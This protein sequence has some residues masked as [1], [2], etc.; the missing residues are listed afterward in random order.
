ML[1]VAFTVP[2]RCVGCWLIALLTACLLITPSK[3]PS[4]IAGSAGLT[5]SELQKSL[6]ES[7]AVFHQ[8]NEL[9]PHDRK[10]AEE[11]YR[12]AAL[13]LERI[14]EQG[15]VRNGRLYYNLGNI[16]LRLEQLGHAILCYRKAEK[17]I[18][19]DEN[20]QQNLAYTLQLRRDDIQG[21]ERNWILG[22]LFGQ[23]GLSPVVRLW[24]FLCCFNLFWI[25]NSVALFKRDSA[26]KKATVLS[27]LL[28]V[29]FG[30][31]LLAD[32]YREGC[33]RQGVIL[34]PEVMARKGDG[35]VYQP[36]F[37][38]PLHAGAEFTLIEQ[39]A[40][41]YHIKLVDGS[42]SWV[43]TAAAGLIDP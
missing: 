23:H 13:Q 27:G 33:H 43:P 37:K 30:G 3:H 17:Y 24:L 14:I 36:S 15:G 7:E 16:Y 4:A 42:R 41:W 9:Y 32:A 1:L 31:S 11:L 39:R 34:Q 20:L 19:R 12:Q 40:G 35:E 18:P 38:G 22:W 6:Q 2:R 26:L 10:R 29:V 28:C 5:K 25:I 8:A 21:A